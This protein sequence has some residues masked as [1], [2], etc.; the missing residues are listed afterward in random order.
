MELA[1]TMK[2]KTI[3]EL[4][5]KCIFV[6]CH[7]WRY[8]CLCVLGICKQLRETGET[9]P[10]RLENVSSDDEEY[11][12]RM[13]KRRRRSRSYSDDEFLPRPIQPVSKI[14]IN[15]SVGDFSK[16]ANFC[17]KMQFLSKKSNFFIKNGYIFY[18]YF[19]N[20]RTVLE[21]WMTMCSVCHFRFHLV[22]S[23]V[24]RS[25]QLKTHVS[26]PFQ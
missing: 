10:D 25:F 21:K 23:I 12:R 20:F 16:M 5:G 15:I 18:W 4:V 3:D 9:S 11:D 13:K 22:S 7:F 1:K 6:S 26:I 8:W 17:P 19:F 14:E 24:A 2:N